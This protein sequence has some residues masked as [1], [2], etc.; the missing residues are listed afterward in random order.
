MTYSIKVCLLDDMH[1]S[2]EDNDGGG[3]EEWNKFTN[4]YSKC[5]KFVQFVSVEINS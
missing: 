1:G 4:F 5:P 2:K 3:G